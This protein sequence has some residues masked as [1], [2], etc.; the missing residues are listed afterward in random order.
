MNS[1]QFSMDKILDWRS[2]QE[3]EARNKVSIMN[4]QL[5]KEKLILDNLLKE[6]RK[7]KKES[8]FS[9]GVDSYRRHD[10]YKELLGEKIT[11]QKRR[12]EQAEQAL[13]EAKEQLVAAHKNKKVME[14]LDEK[15]RTRFTQLQKKEEQKQLDEISTLQ[16]G[17]NILFKH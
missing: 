11:Q 3:D 4:D 15:E 6:S 12:V 13:N 1:Y 7:I 10:M 9:S 17:R 5:N 8:L 2:D 14:K 16:Y